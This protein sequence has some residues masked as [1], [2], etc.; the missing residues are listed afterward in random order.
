MID[1][2]TVLGA[3]FLACVRLNVF[4]YIVKLMKSNWQDKCLIV[5]EV[6]ILALHCHGQACQSSLV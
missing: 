6:L 3:I 1:I 2:E 4:S 5:L